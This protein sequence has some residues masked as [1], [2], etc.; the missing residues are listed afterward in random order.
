MDVFDDE[1]DLQYDDLLPGKSHRSQADAEN[2]MSAQSPSAAARGA[3]GDASIDE[4][5]LEA[6]ARAEAELQAATA[7]VLR[8]QKKRRRPFD[9]AHLASTRGLAM[10]H[11]MAFEALHGKRSSIKVTTKKGR[12]VRKCPNSRDCRASI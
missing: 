4:L 6:V 7:A 8:P 3:S 1:D 12:E 5:A 9:H 11:E 2:G 10:L